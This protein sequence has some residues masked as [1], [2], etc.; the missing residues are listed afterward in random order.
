M[1][2]IITEEI[3]E[4]EEDLKRRGK[5]ESERVL[6]EIKTS[7]AEECL[8]TLYSYARFKSFY[9]FDCWRLNISDMR[10]HIDALQA[11]LYELNVR[12]DIVLNLVLN[13]LYTNR[14][15]DYKPN[16]I[17]NIETKQYEQLD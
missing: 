12:Q 16:Y 10:A 11:R 9:L 13:A 5:L 4:A 2:D 17:Y 7:T 8:S 1:Q 14:F 6:N 15:S 3:L